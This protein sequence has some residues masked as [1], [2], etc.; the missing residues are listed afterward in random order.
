MSDQNENDYSK[1]TQSSLFQELIQKKKNFIIPTTI[2]FFVF[3]FALPI[4]TSYST[5]LNTPAFG[6]ISWAWVFAFAQFAMTWGL[7]LL[8]SNKA[9]SFDKIVEQIKKNGGETK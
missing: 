4:L 1:I 8:Y 9:K 7:C 3:Y 6:P 5:V 2:F